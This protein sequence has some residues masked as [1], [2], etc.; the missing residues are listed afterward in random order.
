MSLLLSFR[1]SLY[2]IYIYVAHPISSRAIAPLRNCSYVGVPCTLPPA[3]G[4]SGHCVVR[5][6]SIARVGIVGFCLILSIITMWFD[7]QVRNTS[8][9]WL[10]ALT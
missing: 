9:G 1:G 5:T 6:S 3:S 4:E 2:V 7:L 10:V 8:L